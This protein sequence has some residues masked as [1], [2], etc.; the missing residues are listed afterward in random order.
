MPGASW[1]HS[2]LLLCLPGVPAVYIHSLLGSRNWDEGVRLTRRA[3]TINRAKLDMEN[4]VS[5]IENPETF[6]SRV[7]STY[8]DDDTE[9]VVLNRPFILRRVLM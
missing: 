1:R 7:F 4:L 3:R 5:E 8:R 2:P 9:Y 6:R